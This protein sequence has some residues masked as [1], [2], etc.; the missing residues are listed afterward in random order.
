LDGGRRIL[1]APSRP[2]AG[3]VAAGAAN[4]VLLLGN[5][6]QK[7][8]R[9]TFLHVQEGGPDAAPSAAAYRRP[10][11]QSSEDNTQEGSEAARAPGRGG[12]CQAPRPDTPGRWQ[13]SLAEFHTQDGT[14][15]QRTIGAAHVRFV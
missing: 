2:A 8:E 3:Q 12:A 1:P 11:R 4:N 14:F 5:H 13:R 9:P 10:R 7:T 15:A 6:G